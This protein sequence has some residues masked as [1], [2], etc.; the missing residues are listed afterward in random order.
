MSLVAIINK[1]DPVLS[2]YL[3]RMAHT[4]EDQLFRQSMQKYVYPF[5]TI[6]SLHMEINNIPMIRKIVPH[7]DTQTVH[8]V[9]VRRSKFATK[10]EQLEPGIKDFSKI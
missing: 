4:V 8:N 1:P 5:E 9:P 6:F 10:F 2:L 7:E 3:P